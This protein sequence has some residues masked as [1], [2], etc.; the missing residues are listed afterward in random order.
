MS[1]AGPVMMRQCDYLPPQPG[2]P[3]RAARIATR[4]W[5]LGFPGCIVA[6]LALY[7]AAALLYRA[8]LPYGPSVTTGVEIAVVSTVSPALA[9]IC[10]AIAARADDAGHPVLAPGRLPPATAALPALASGLLV[11]AAYTIGAV[12]LPDASTL[13]QMIRSQPAVLVGIPAS[14]TGGL[15]LLDRLR[16][17]RAQLTGID[18]P[19]PSLD[20]QSTRALAPIQSLLT[21]PMTF[22]LV[23]GHAVCITAWRPLSMVAGL[24][25]LWAAG[26]LRALVVEMRTGHPK[27]APAPTHARID[28]ASRA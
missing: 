6:L 4:L 12:F 16:L 21:F 13:A 10:S 15:M 28:A 17:P 26:F 22:A 2:W 20:V 1:E 8:A 14:I 27:S 7:G 3:G 23:F 11:G 19:G 18:I 24:G 5:L 25:V 9:V